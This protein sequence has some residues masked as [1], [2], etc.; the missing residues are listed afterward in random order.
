MYIETVFFFCLLHSSYSVKEPCVKPGTGLRKEIRLSDRR[1]LC[2]WVLTGKSTF[3]SS[4]TDRSGVETFLC[5]QCDERSRLGTRSSGPA[6][7]GSP[8]SP[9]IRTWSGGRCGRVE[10]WVENLTPVD[11]TWVTQWD[12]RSRLGFYTHGGTDT[13]NGHSFRHKMSLLFV[14][15]KGT[16]VTM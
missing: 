2:L 5:P 16:R 11:A 8:L 4:T 7:E 14:L 1:A 10:V 9:W 6:R 15:V 12:R 13:L 3:S